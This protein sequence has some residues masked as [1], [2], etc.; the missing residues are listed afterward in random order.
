MQL[1]HCSQ[2]SSQCQFS[3]N[4]LINALSRDFLHVIISS[5]IL[6]KQ[7]YQLHKKWGLKD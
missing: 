5:T 7:S 2:R 6:Y 1:H 4:T 3:K